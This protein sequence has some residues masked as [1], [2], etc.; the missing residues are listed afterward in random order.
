MQYKLIF[1]FTLLKFLNY[2]GQTKSFEN[3]LM[4]PLGILKFMEN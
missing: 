4:I 2:F 1:I 3:Y